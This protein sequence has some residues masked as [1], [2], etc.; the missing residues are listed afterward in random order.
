MNT[1][2]IAYIRTDFPEKFGLP[3]QSG[4]VEELEGVIEFTE[5]YRDPEAVRGLEG[6]EYLWLIWQFE[7][8]REPGEW[9]P[10]VRPPRLGGNT[11]IGVFATRSP[12]RPNPIGLSCVRLKS[13]EYTSE[14]PK[15][16]VTGID[17]R[18]KTPIFDIKPYL[19]YADAHPGAAAGF[20]D[21][22]TE[23]ENTKL[24]RVEDPKGVL[25]NLPEE[26]RQGAVKLLAQDIR[27]GYQKDP[28]RI[29]GVLFAGFNIRFSSDGESVSVVDV[30]PLEKGSK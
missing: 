24:L 7:T 10:T 16:H 22:E 18:D 20:T 14:G 11:R 25:L 21:S 15:I 12:F 6:F 27:P 19:P 26:K 1:E 9:S 3:R 30:E 2:V 28:D 13:V 5:K 4:L 23:K 8:G 29:Y 17:M